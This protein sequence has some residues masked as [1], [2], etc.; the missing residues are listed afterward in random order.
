MHFTQ[1]SALERAQ[2]LTSIKVATRA[3]RDTIADALGDFRFSS[4][5]RQDAVA[6]GPHGHRRA[7]RRDAA[8]LP[9]PRRDAHPAGPAQGRLRHRHARRRHQRPD[10]HG[11]VQ[12]TVEVRRHP[13]APPAGPRVPA[14]RRTRRTGRATTRSATSSSRRPSTRSRTPGWSARPATTPRS[15]KRIQRKKPPEG[16]VSWGHGTFEKLSTG[17]PEPLVSRMQVSHA[18]VLDV[19]S[20][21][22]DARAAA[23]APGPRERA[24]PTQERMLAEVDDD[25]RGAARGRAS[26]RSSTRPTRRDAPLRLTVDLQ[27][28][29]ALNQPLVAVRGGGARPARPRSRRRTRSTSSRSS[30]PRS[31][32]RARSSTR[33]ATAR[34]ARPSAEMKMDGIEYDERMELLEDVEHPKP[35]REE[36]E[37]AATRRTASVTRGSPTT[38]CSPSR[39]SARCGSGP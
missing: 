14:D 3:E 28:N 20:R 36:L 15:C 8:A 27:A 7:P 12:R 38:S 18:M 1:A 9:P 37:T 26:S 21:P 39:S 24:R 34:A 19:V 29:F 31:T 10:P 35:L 23:R 17:T 2:A 25:H 4:G 30:R 22:G 33:S 32:T 13:P 16:F 5:V 11:A 6:A